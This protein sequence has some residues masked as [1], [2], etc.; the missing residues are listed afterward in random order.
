MMG[1]HTFGP[2]GGT[3]SSFLLPVECGCSQTAL[4]EWNGAEV[5]MRSA[6][7]GS[8][9]G[10]LAVEA[11]LESSKDLYVQTQPWSWVGRPLHHLIGL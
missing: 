7:V 5:K 9:E 6:L 3:P 11:L 8:F 1:L 10:N 2:Y 4:G